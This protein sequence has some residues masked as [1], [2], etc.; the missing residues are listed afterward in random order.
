M[1]V[2]ALVLGP[3]L[4]LERPLAD[5]GDVSLPVGHFRVE[6]APVS[7]RRT[8]SIALSAAALQATGCARTPSPLAP[9]LGGSIGLPH[10]GVLTQ[11]AEL[12]ARGEGYRWL[13][14]DD[15]HHGLP[16]F[17]R[18]IER[19]AA[20]VARERPGAVLQVGDLSTRSGGRLVPHL[21]HRTG[22]DAD[23]LLYMT[24]L[25]GAPVESPGF[26]H[27]GSDGLAWDAEQN[28][29]LR[30]DVERTWLLIKALLEDRDA[31]VQWIFA[32]RN[33]EAMLVE[34][35]RARGESGETIVRAMDVMLEPHPGGPHDDHVHVRTA[36]S[37]AEILAG[38]E[39]TGPH[40]AWLDGALGDAVST[41]S[42][43][44]LID[45]ILHPLAPSS[46]TERTASKFARSPDAAPR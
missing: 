45:A 17:I 27:V 38:C 37:S 39:H 9:Q 11:S 13:R 41:V 22:R 23:L 25:D 2:R 44:E 30:F 1:Y 35:A 10:R 6:L 15:R 20:H 7:L 8:L 18:A 24:T 28:R 14:Q 42:E 46:S 36:C 16:R 34:W 43:G 19:A 40:R 5:D 12:P 26:I 3:R 21:S 4:G 32:H 33:V 31:R 29:F